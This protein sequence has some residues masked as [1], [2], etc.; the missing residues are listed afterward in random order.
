[1][2]RGE[3]G[4]DLRRKRERGI[5]RKNGG[6]PKEKTRGGRESSS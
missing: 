3:K 6:V 5:L 4:K 2:S 1:M